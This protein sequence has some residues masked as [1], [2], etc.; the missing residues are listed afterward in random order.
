MTAALPIY[1]AQA[2]PAP[3]A[4]WLQ[5]LLQPVLQACRFERGLP[6]EVRPTGAWG[7]WCPERQSAPDRRVVLS[8]RIC[9]WTAENI[10]SVY[11]HES[12][13][14]FLEAREVATHGAEFFCLN[15]ILLL[16]CASLFRLDPLFKLDLYDLQDRPPELDSELG[17]RGLVLDWA[18]PLASALAAS[19][20]N[21]EAL[22][23][24]VCQSWQMF[25]EEREKAREQ[26]AQQIL[27][28]RKKA[29][30]AE[31]QIENL[32]SSLFVAR[33]FLVVGWMC[34]LSVCIFVF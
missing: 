31:V 25:L 3:L 7:G 33:T 6:V 24:A 17:W 13:H 29:A 18:I 5:R 34:F 11:L 4:A 20:A 22:A 28:A 14:R 32:K 21:A 9:F 30:A 19:T 16:R 12:T 10:I 15:A 23:D 1:C 8:N 2:A 27:A 26:D